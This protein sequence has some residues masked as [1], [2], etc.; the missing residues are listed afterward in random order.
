VDPD[1]H[2][3]KSN[4]KL[5][6]IAIR[7]KYG[8]IDK[9]TRNGMTVHPPLPILGSVNESEAPEPMALGLELLACCVVHADSGVMFRWSYAYIQL[10]N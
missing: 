5:N 9:N 1:L 7:S 4:N 2:F 10:G 6:N 8:L 3:G